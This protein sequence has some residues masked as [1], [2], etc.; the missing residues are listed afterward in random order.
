MRVS[1]SRTLASSLLCLATFALPGTAAQQTSPQAPAADSASQASVLRIAKEVRKAILSLPEYGVFDYI[2]F[3]IKGRTVILKGEASRPILKSSAENVVKKIEGVESVQ[4][5]IDVLPNSPNDD[6]IRAGV[7][8]RIYSQPSLQK[9]TSNRGPQFNS[10]TR[11]TMGITYDPPIGY[12]A[13]HIIVKN[14]NVTLVGAVD[15]SSDAALAAMQANLTPGVFSVDN[16]LFVASKDG[17]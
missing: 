13:I 17:K 5:D 4:N 12:H 8:Y 2:H 16:D 15:N 7:Y 3:A 9:Y 1:L 11:R 14:G 10:L 6:R